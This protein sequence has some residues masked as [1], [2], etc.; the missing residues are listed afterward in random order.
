MGAGKVGQLFAAYLE[1]NP[2]WGYEVRGFLDSN[3]L[4][5]PRVLGDISD[6]GRVA[7]KEFI[8][9][10]FITIL[11]ERELVK[12]V[13]LEAHQLGICSKV[14]PELYDGL[15]WQKPVESLGEFN[16]RVMYREPIPAPELLF[17][18]LMDIVGSA[19][20]LIILS[21]VFGLI[22]LAI[23]M[24]SPGPVFYSANRVGRKGR[25]FTCTHKFRTMV[26][27]AEDIKDK[28]RHLNERQ[29]PFFKITGDP[30][31]TSVGRFLRQYSLDELPQ[32]AERILWRHPESGRT[33]PASAGRL[34]TVHAP[35]SAPARCH[36]GHH[37]LVADYRSRRSV[38]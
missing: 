35:A 15:A 8:D 33:T 10:I 26:Q 13:V 7:R 14:I 37:L 29:G 22:A 18:R 20:G 25:K 19:I 36:T 28:L 11:S 16:V 1:Q 31:I 24:N 17:K 4:D 27:N 23:K 32:L 2:G 12:R 3:F 9:E 5:D 6:L 30:R 34:Q 38:L 21:P